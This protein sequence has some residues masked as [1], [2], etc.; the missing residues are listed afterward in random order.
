MF[1]M[2]EISI[3]T[4]D[5]DVEKKVKEKLIT[6]LG[7]SLFSVSA[8]Q[9][10][11]DLSEIGRIKNISLTRVWPQTLR[12]QIELKTPYSKIKRDNQFYSLDLDGEFIEPLN[13]DVALLE[14]KG[15]YNSENG[16]WV[17]NPVQKKEFFEFLSKRLKE[18]DSQVDFTSTHFVEWNNLE[19]LKLSW[20]EPTLE[21][22]LGNDQFEQAWGRAKKA[23]VYIKKQKLNIENLDATYQNRVV[24]RTRRELQNSEYRLNLEELVR[25]TENS[26]SP[27]AR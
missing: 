24:A 19:G 21:I 27:S 14:L 25:R 3:V 15:F 11:K 5:S 8:Q 9:I 26:S 16:R 4:E 20:G 13:Q 23:I 22:V 10:S 2:S 1:R 12:I 18:D 17:L 7:R 6:Y